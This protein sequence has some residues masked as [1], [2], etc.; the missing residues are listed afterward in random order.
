DGLAGQY[1][2]DY[3]GTLFSLIFDL[4]D[5][6]VDVCFGIPT[7]NRWQNPITF[8]GPIGVTHFKAIFPD[9]SIECDELWTS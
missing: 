6:K 9:K 4:T 7:H 3:F 1:Y 5:L 8:D 2:T